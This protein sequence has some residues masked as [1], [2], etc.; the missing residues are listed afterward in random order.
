MRRSSAAMLPSLLAR[1]PCAPRCSPRGRWLRAALAGSVPLKVVSTPE[2]EEVN[3]RERAPH[4]KGRD[5][6]E[7]PTN[8]YEGIQASS[9][10]IWC[11][12]ATNR[13]P[14]SHVTWGIADS[15]LHQ[16]GVSCLVAGEQGFPG[17]GHQTPQEEEIR[18]LKREMIC[19][20]R[21]VIS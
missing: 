14:R 4:R 15:T 7:D 20:H 21:S 3:L 12:R 8:L 13:R 9:L 10:S 18:H 17:S 19:G 1:S 6:A 16:L 5:H 2:V 11:N